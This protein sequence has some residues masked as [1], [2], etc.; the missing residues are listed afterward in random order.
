MGL[1]N[2]RKKREVNNIRVSIRWKQLSWVARTVLKNTTYDTRRTSD[3]MNALCSQI[4]CRK[5]WLNTVSNV[6]YS[7]ICSR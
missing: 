7:S 4:Q 6:P 1:V 5:I 2:T 3:H